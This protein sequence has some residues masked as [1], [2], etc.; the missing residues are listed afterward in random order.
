MAGSLQ[1]CI[2]CVLLFLLRSN[3]ADQMLRSQQGPFGWQQ[4]SCWIWV[5][6]RGASVAPDGA[7]GMRFDWKRGFWPGA[8]RP[9][10]GS[11]CWGQKIQQAHL[12]PADPGFIPTLC[13]LGHRWTFSFIFTDTFSLFLLFFF[14]L[15]QEHSKG[16]ESGPR[17]P[18][19]GLPLWPRP[20]AAGVPSVAHLPARR[21]WRP[22]L[23]P[24]WRLAPTA[25][26]WVTNAKDPGEAEE[27]EGLLPLSRW[28]SHSSWTRAK[29]Q[30]RA[31]NRTAVYARANLQMP[32]FPW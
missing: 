28:S 15:S 27:D 7:R 8:V 5:V 1:E 10:A 4:H 11:R 20:A 9:L 22:P 6:G 31:G 17:L 3:M 29:H 21:L 26:Q 14:V 13:Q 16:C 24:R 32:L 30:D 25:V 18:G 2:F 19:G 12:A 23:D